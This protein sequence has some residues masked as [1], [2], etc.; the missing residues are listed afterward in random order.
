MITMLATSLTTNNICVGPI[1]SAMIA[2]KSLDSSV[3]E[4]RGMHI[5]IATMDGMET[6]ALCAGGV[7]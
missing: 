3:M 4:K 2:A 6:V 7:C 5:G 1:V